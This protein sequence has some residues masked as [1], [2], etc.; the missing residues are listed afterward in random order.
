MSEQRNK[1]CDGCEQAF[2]DN[3]FWNDRNLCEECFQ[4]AYED[5]EVA[6]AEARADGR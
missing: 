1:E 3:S 2:A 4:V 6:K 5:A